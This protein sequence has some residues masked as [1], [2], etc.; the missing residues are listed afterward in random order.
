MHQH[1]I[2]LT[3]VFASTGLPDID[4]NFLLK[5]L[6]AVVLFLIMWNQG[7]AAFGKKGA[8]PDPV[9]VRSTPDDVTRR[10]HDELVKDLDE[11]KKELP[12]ME[13]R[14][15]RE[16]KIYGKGAYEGRQKIWDQVNS[17][18]AELSAVKARVTTLE[19]N[20]TCKT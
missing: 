12:E 13:R 16:I 11:L 14:I 17:D 20:R 6:G 10:E 7:K 15:I 9:N 1:L 4:G 19:N 18:R 8:Y 3:G 2:A 5:F